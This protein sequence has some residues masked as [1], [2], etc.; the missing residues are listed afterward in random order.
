[1]AADE[2]AAAIVILLDRDGNKIID[3]VERNNIVPFLGELACP[4]F[5]SSLPNDVELQKAHFVAPSRQV[6]ETVV[7]SS[8]DGCD[9]RKFND[10]LK[11]VTAILGSWRQDPLIG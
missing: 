9:I 10:E 1:M 5:D 7:M 6:I 2:V 4:Y 11:A 3:A 8:M